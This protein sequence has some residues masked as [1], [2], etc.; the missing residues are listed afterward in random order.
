MIVIAILATITESFN[1]TGTVK[2]QF[3][4]N[5]NREINLSNQ[6]Y[7][8]PSGISVI[9]TSQ[10]GATIQ[11]NLSE[12]SPEHFSNANDLIRLIGT[13]SGSTFI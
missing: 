5:V 1:I 2:A 9:D 3:Q 13:E 12:T 8:T 6:S 11:I 10:T 4:D 7:S